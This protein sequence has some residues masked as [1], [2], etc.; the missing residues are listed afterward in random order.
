M[1]D[2]PLEIESRFSVFFSESW[3]DLDSNDGSGF[4]ITE[5]LKI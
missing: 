3:L 2:L 1:K 5:A 4:P